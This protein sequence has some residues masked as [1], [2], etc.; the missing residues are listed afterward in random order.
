MVVLFSHNDS[1][2]IIRNRFRTLF[3][4]E[5]V[6]LFTF[7]RFEIFSF[8]HQAPD[9]IEINRFKPVAMLN[10][11]NDQFLTNRIPGFLQKPVVCFSPVLLRVVKKREPRGDILSPTIINTYNEHIT[12]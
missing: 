11:D 7:Y 10:F 1:L 9:F 4:F 6:W 3:R 5:H 12:A 2:S 8:P